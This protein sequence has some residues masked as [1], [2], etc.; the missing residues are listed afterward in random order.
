[1]TLKHDSLETRHRISTG[2]AV[3]QMI[4]CIR[5]EVWVIRAV[6]RTVYEY[7]AGI[8]KWSGTTLNALSDYLIF[9]R[10]TEVMVNVL[11]LEI[12]FKGQR[13]MWSP[14]GLSLDLSA[15]AEDFVSFWKS[16]M[17]SY[18]KKYMYINT[19]YSFSLFYFLDSFLTLAAILGI[20]MGCTAM[21]IV[22]AA[23]CH[24]RLKNRKNKVQVKRLVFNLRN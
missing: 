8:I 12:D 6:E 19:I 5:N 20:S 10:K 1:M 16:I 17:N 3:N 18:I 21:I 23:F 7:R 2:M 4:N 22:I 14:V 15:L 13:L 24:F 9:V 11:W